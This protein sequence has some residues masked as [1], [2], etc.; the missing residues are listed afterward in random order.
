VHANNRAYKS[1]YAYHKFCI[2][3]KAPTGN[4]RY[5]SRPLMMQ[6]GHDAIAGTP[7]H[8]LLMCHGFFKQNPLLNA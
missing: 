7:L 3:G 6:R 8:T 5:A 1:L 2:S 4:G